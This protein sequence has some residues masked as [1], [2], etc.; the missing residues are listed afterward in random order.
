MRDFLKKEYLDNLI[1][2]FD[3]LNLLLDDPKG[4]ANTPL[5][6]RNKLEFNY[7]EN[8]RKI[9]SHESLIFNQEK[10]SEDFKIFVLTKS[11]IDDFIFYQQHFKKTNFDFILNENIPKVID[12]KKLTKKIF[13]SIVFVEN[14]LNIK[15][16]VSLNIFSI[17]FLL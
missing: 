7:L 14:K 13:D 4:F 11:N 6:A 8:L 16:L 15:E 3:N 9:I 1:K 5:E 10:K 17:I 2:Y 12:S